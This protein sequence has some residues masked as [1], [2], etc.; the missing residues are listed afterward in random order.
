MT[1]PLFLLYLIDILLEKTA[2][3]LRKLVS[4]AAQ[5]LLCARISADMHSHT[6]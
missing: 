3:F 2:K 1:H 6:N 4:L 5:Q